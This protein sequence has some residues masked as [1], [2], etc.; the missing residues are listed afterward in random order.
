MQSVALKF[1]REEENPTRSQCKSPRSPR[2]SGHQ[3]A[4]GSRVTSEFMEQTRK[5]FQMQHPLSKTNSYPQHPEHSM[6]F[7]NST[8]CVYNR[9]PLAPGIFSS[10]SQKRQPLTSCGSLRF[11]ISKAFIRLR[12]EAR[13]FVAHPP[14]STALQPSSLQAL[15]SPGLRTLAGLSPP[16][17]P[18]LAVF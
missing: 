11:Q 18:V 8:C 7:L 5:I 14:A 16:R 1:S 4:W 10:Y 13:P 9:S 12:I 15:C 17:E 6:L 3:A 2:Q